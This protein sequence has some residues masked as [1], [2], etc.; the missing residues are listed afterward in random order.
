MYLR[1]PNEVDKAD[2]AAYLIKG[3][4][5]NLQLESVSLIINKCKKSRQ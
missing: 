2:K 1:P 3:L 5:F 4:D